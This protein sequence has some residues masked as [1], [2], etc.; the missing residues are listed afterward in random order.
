MPHER[1]VLAAQR[2]HVGDGAERGVGHRI[3]EELA[4]L[5]AVEHAARQRVRD[6][7][8][9]P[10]RDADARKVAVGISRARKP[11]VEHRERGRDVLAGAVVVR[12]DDV[13]TARLDAANRV[14][15]VGAV[16]D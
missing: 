9:E 3:D 1:A 15:R 13:R 4:E 11:W 5:G 8:R 6:C 2:R 7:G 16:V 12:D 10:E 14:D